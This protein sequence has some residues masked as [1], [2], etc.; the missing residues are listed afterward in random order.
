M[1]TKKVVHLWNQKY[2]IPALKME[3]KKGVYFQTLD[4]RQNYFSIK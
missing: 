3:N 2:S 4:F 1:F